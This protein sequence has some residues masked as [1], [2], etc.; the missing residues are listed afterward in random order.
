MEKYKY[1]P[2][3]YNTSHP[4]DDDSGNFYWPGLPPV[5]YDEAGI[6]ID[7]RGYQC[8]DNSSPLNPQHT[9]QATE[10][11]KGLDAYI[12]TF[13]NV[14]AWFD[15]NFLEITD[16][17]VCYYILRWYNYQPNQ[18]QKYIDLVRESESIEEVIAQAWPDVQKS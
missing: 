1:G 10:Y 8:L 12:P 7:E 4:D 18:S 14:K 17:Q 5:G 2:L 13:D 6:P 3:V 9:P 11:N 16:W 15:D